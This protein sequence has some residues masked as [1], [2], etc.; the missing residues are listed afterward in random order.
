MIEKLGYF[1]AALG[2]SIIGGSVIAAL[3]VIVMWAMS[4]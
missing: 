1:L 2:L 3:I 4:W